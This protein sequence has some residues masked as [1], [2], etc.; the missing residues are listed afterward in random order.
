MFLTNDM[1]VISWHLSSMYWHPLA[2]ALTYT[3]T[4]AS[5]HHR[6]SFCG[7][8]IVSL[9]KIPV[10]T[11]ASWSSI[12]S[13]RTSN[14]SISWNSKYVSDGMFWND[15]GLGDVLAGDHPILSPQGQDPGLCQRARQ[16]VLHVCELLGVFYRWQGL[17]QHPAD[18]PSHSPWGLASSPLQLQH[19][20]VSGRQSLFGDVVSCGAKS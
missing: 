6:D 2:R 7:L 1:L 17:P 16:Q 11:A 8:V 12:I 3:Y 15:S 13:C 4:I 19:Y 14:Q 18:D 9:H 20:R 5:T 10:L